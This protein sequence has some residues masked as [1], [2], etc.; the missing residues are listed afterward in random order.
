LSVNQNLKDKKVTYPLKTAVAAFI[1]TSLLMSIPAWGMT[2]DSAP[3]QKPEIQHLVGQHPMLYTLE[4]LPVEQLSPL[5]S[6]QYLH[7][8]QSTFVRWIM[9]KGAIVPLHSHPN[10]QITWITKGHAEVYSGGKKY[11]MQAGD[12]LIIPPNVPHEFMFTEDTIDIDFFSPQRQDWIDGSANYLKTPE[13][14]SAQNVAVGK[15]A[16]HPGK[17]FSTAIEAGDYVFLSGAIG[18]G[19]KEQPVIGISA[20]TEQIMEQLK[21]T[22]ALSGLKMDNVVKATVFIRNAEDFAQMND[23]YHRYFPTDPPARSTLVTGF[24]GSEVLV[25]IEMIAYRGSMK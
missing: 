17:N 10:E 5:I 3:V 15:K 25:E 19:S 8:V 16:I 2:A 11:S 23:V 24:P 14:P 9:K 1:A 21:S 7:G 12:I 6:R 20:Q 22:L 4:K 18:S 13:Q